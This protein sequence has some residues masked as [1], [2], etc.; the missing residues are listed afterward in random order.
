MEPIALHDGRI[1][2]VHEEA[3]CLGEFCCIHNPSDH[4]L[5]DAPLTW[6]PAWGMMRV[7][8]HGMQ[9]PD[10]D[11]LAVK[12]LLFGIRDGLLMVNTVCSVH[13]LEEG[14][15]DGCCYPRDE[16]V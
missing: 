6:I 12:P 4:P 14:Q 5:R 3:D 15:C 2:Q 10:P 13:Y 16:E 11:D 9:H 1:L 8:P 7:C